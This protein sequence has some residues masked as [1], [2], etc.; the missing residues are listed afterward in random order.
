MLMPLKAISAILSYPT[1][2]LQSAGLEL[3]AALAEGDLLTPEL[4]DLMSRLVDDITTSGATLHECARV[5]KQA[6]AK[7]VYALVLAVAGH[8]R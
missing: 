4:L 3:K 8:G 5:L 2:E 1:E 6:G 7:Q